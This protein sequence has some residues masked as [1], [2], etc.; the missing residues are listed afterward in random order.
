MKFFTILAAAQGIYF[1]LTGIWPL[2]HIESFID[3]T[4]YKTD[5]WLVK[6]VGA[7]V[8]PMS[9]TLLYMAWRAKDRTPAIILGMGSALA[10]IIIDCYYAL[11]DTIRDIYLADAAAEAVIFFAWCFVIYKEVSHSKVI[12]INT[13]P[14]K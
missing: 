7:L 8:L 3:V 11:N 12:H 1:L 10:F 9:F 13:N 6:T 14:G 5:L 4:G 2:V